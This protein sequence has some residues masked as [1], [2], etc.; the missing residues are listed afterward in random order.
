MKK[1]QKSLKLTNPILIMNDI[2]EQWRIF[3]KKKAEQKEADEMK[4]AELTEK[5]FENEKKPIN[6]FIEKY[7][8]E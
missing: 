6:E 5:L 1:L 4:V 8:K 2:K 7:R 3:R